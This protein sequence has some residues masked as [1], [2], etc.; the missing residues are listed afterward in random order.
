M[1]DQKVIRLQVKPK[2]VPKVPVIQESVNRPSI[3][4]VPLVKSEY[5][6]V[7]NKES[8]KVEGKIPRF[9]PK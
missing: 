9:V 2:E 8:E 7:T 5:K 1:K 4:K 3:V 6:S